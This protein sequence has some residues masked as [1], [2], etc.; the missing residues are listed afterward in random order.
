MPSS[1]SPSGCNHGIEMRTAARPHSARC[2][3][4]PGV[5]P[6]RHSGGGWPAC[7]CRPGCARSAI[8]GGLGTL[9]APP[10]VPGAIRAGYGFG[11]DRHFLF[12]SVPLMNAVLRAANAGRGAARQWRGLVAGRARC[13][14]ARGGASAGACRCRAH[15]CRRARRRGGLHRPARGSCG[16]EDALLRHRAG[17]PGRGA[18]ALGLRARGFT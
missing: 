13:A 8:P 1:S 12:S 11:R 18:G 2:W 9:P 10:A 14:G 5:C 6:G 16:G 3:G 4:A 17:L 15:L 7:R